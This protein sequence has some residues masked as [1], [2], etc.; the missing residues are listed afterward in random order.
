MSSNEVGYTE[1]LT[2]K[3][4]I[5]KRISKRLLQTRVHKRDYVTHFNAVAR[6]I[7]IAPSI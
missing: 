3:T 1:R 6:M 4:N 2:M 7:M 5:E